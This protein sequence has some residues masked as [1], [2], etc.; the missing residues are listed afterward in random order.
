MTRR[1]S[2]DSLPSA[3]SS[4]RRVDFSSR[5]CS[6]PPLPASRHSP[7]S[8]RALSAEV[9]DVRSRGLLVG[10]DSSL[11]SFDIVR[12]GAI[13]VVDGGALSAIACARGSR[14]VRGESLKCALVL[15]PDA[16]SGILRGLRNTR[17][18]LLSRSIEREKRSNIIETPATSTVSL[19]T[20]G[21]NSISP[22]LSRFSLH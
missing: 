6:L 15:R 8:L 3:A 9:T 19:D 5:R 13:L 7:P 4:A 1:R 18:I 2:D 21:L 11:Y 12:R 17:N 22:H 20:S 16:S 14:V 10:L